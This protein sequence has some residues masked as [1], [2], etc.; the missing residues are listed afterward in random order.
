MQFFALNLAR[1][2]IYEKSTI[3]PTHLHKETRHRSGSYCKYKE[4]F[5]PVLHRKHP[6]AKNG[7]VS[8]KSPSVR[9]TRRLIALFTGAF[10]IEN[11]FSELLRTS[12]KH[13]SDMEY[14]CGCFE[15]ITMRKQHWAVHLDGQSERGFTALTKKQ[16]IHNTCR[17]LRKQQM[18]V[19][20]LLCTT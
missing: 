4:T 3:Q 17:N 10:H 1:V 9:G 14:N 6:H 20:V 7:S 11:L 8:Q 5:C 12:R 19:P 15:Q 2:M 16:I 18:S 13:Y